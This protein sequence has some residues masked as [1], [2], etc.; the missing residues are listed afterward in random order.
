[1]RLIMSTDQVMHITSALQ[2]IDVNPANNKSNL[3]NPDYQLDKES[4]HT[5]NPKR[6]LRMAFDDVVN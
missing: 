1:M 3:E 6:N 4:H 5:G 2:E